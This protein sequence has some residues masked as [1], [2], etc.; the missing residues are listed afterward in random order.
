MGGPLQKLIQTL[1]MTLARSAREPDSCLVV[2]SRQGAAPRREVH[3]LEIVGQFKMSAGR[4]DESSWQHN[5]SFVELLQ[6]A[7]AQ[8]GP[9]IER[10]RE[11]A[12][13][14]PDGR[15][16]VLD[17]RTPDP[18]GSVPIHD[19]LGS[20]A[21]EAGQ[22]VANSWQANDE[23]RLFTEDGFFMLP[24]ELCVMVLEELRARLA[25]T[26]VTRH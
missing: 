23:H 22:I 6:T 20:F 25:G 18:T 3:Q 26:G 19:V 2:V 4:L 1:P 10:L 14:H 12:V 11:A 9:N 13:G 15:M 24:E 16:Y 7:I 17:G 5:G 21:I 8:Y